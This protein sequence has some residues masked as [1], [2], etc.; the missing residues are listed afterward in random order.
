MSWLKQKTI[1]ITGATG[2][3]GSELV[4]QL[5]KIDTKLI[6][7]DIG[8]IGTEQ[9]PENLREKVVGTFSADLSSEEGCKKAYEN[10][11][12]ISPE[13]DILINNAGV[14]IVGGFL[15]IPNEKWKKLLDIN[16]YA[17]VYLT[18]LFL[19]AMLERGIGHIVNISSVAGHFAHKDLNYYSIS[20]FGIR[21][22]GEA[23]YSEVFSKGVAV[24]NVYPF[25]TDTK[26][27]SSEQ[28]TVEKRELPSY[29]VD[30]VEDVVSE[31]IKGMEKRELHIFPGFR[32][33]GMN[34]FHRIFP[35]VTSFLARGL[36]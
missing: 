20:K 3:I 18:R 15:D 17:P 7:T 33:K 13:V 16:L 36:A 9:I 8:E 24:S 31:I 12:N 29:L 35:E 23:L 22:M 6:L 2:G 1:L 27:L 14:A 34:F 10:A 25:F 26:I 28:Y 5:S 32:A 30:K 19:P 21:A 11:L 4:K